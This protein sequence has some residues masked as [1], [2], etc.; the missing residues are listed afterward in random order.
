MRIDSVVSTQEII[1]KTGVKLNKT[2]FLSGGQMYTTFSKVTPGEEREEES[3]K[4]SEFNGVKETT[5]KFVPKGG[6]F[7]SRGSFS[8]SRPISDPNTMLMAYAK[9]IAIAGL[10]AGAYK[11]IQDT[12]K[13]FDA[14]VD[15]IVQKY[16]SLQ[17][18]GTAAV[19]S[20]KEAVA[21]SSSMPS[22]N[23]YKGDDEDLE[24]VPF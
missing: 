5:I 17:S 19:E 12:M 23:D 8:G 3:R 6:G 15:V 14:A 9:D 21:R 10:N 16:R 2:I 18:D 20:A 4:E 11:T 1:T 24:E 22:D 7:G 13:A